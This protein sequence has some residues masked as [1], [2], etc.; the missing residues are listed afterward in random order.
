MKTYQAV[1]CQI[2][3]V[4]NARKKVKQVIMELT[5]TGNPSKGKPSPDS[6]ILEEEFTHIRDLCLQAYPALE[7]LITNVLTS[8]TIFLFTSLIY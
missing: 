5:G 7:C 3:N 4:T 6:K 1:F 8:L 2:P